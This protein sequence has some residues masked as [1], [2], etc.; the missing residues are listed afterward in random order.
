MS[1]SWRPHGWQPIRLPHP[2]D[3]P[4]TQKRERQRQKIMDSACIK[5]KMN[6]VVILILG[7]SVCMY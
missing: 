4:G 5:R 1:D 2:W 3:S 7:P 6:H